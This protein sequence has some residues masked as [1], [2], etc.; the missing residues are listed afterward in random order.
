[1]NCNDI[2]IDMTISDLC[3]I[4]KKIMQ[5]KK[6]YPEKYCHLIC[7]KCNIDQTIDFYINYDGV[8]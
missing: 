5:V 8:K 1:M 3:P 7:E 4:C 6:D 2:E